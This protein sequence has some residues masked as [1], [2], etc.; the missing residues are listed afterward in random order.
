MLDA[1]ARYSK[2]QKLTVKGAGKIAYTLHNKNSEKV[3]ASLITGLKEAIKWHTDRLALSVPHLL[4][5]QV[6]VLR[7]GVR[8]NGR[9]WK[10]G[11]HC[12]FYL[13]TDYQIRAK[14]RVGIVR[15]FVLEKIGTKQQLFVVLNERDEIDRFRSMVVFDITKP[16]KNTIVHIDLVANLVGSLPFWHAGRPDI[17]T[18]VP[19]CST[20]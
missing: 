10:A 7:A 8:I 3:E 13:P 17:R 1:D 18:G 5:E 20:F 14:N 16:L 2:R 6:L 9:P 4:G 19:I 11:D 12:F 15:F